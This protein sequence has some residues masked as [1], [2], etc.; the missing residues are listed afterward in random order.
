M[1]FAEE[2]KIVIEGWLREAMRYG[3]KL[4]IIGV[5]PPA[6]TFDWRDGYPKIVAEYASSPYEDLE[7]WVGYDGEPTE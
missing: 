5:G 2:E 4:A 3:H 7:P 1:L 6:P